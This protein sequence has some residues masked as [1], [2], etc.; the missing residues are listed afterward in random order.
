MKEYVKYSLPSFVLMILMAIGFILFSRGCFQ[1]ANTEEVKPTVIVTRD[2]Q[3]IQ[4]PP[5]TIPQYQPIIIET[6]APA[7]IPQ[8]YQPSNNQEVLLKQYQDLVEKFLTSHR[9]K[10][11]IVLKDS[12]L[13]EVGIVRLDDIVSE[14]EIKSRAPSYALKFPVI[15][16][17]VTITQPYLPRNQWFVGGALNGNKLNLVDVFKAGV[18]IKNKKDQI[19]S[20][21][22]TISTG[23]YLGAELGYYTKIRL[24]KK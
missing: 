13:R 21:N 15:T 6:K 7:V 18:L 20:I 10:D 5:V 24:S 4:Q 3:Y 8:Q 23:G 12:A 9:Y 14:N 17:T 1:A 2:T 22:G 19:F 11:S 16:N